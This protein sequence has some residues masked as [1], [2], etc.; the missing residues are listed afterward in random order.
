M[1]E[2]ESEGERW[3]FVSDE[4]VWPRKAAWNVLGGWK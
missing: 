3:V 4:C 2:M 1:I